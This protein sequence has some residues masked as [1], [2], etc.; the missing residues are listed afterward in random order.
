MSVPRALAF[1]L[2]NLLPAAA[3]TFGTVVA[4]PQPL[5]DLAL[6][7][8]RRRLYVV[9]TA[10]NQVE[11]Y[12]TASNPPRQTNA[13]KTSSTPL[14]IAMSRSGRYLYVACYVAASFGI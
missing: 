4:H 7:E 14:S 3:A 2:L 13:I 9:N 5:A 8:A 10:L 6:D 11:V 1:L 12:S